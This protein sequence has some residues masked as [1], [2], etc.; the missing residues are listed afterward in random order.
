[1]KRYL[2][3]IA[4]TLLHYMSF[5][6]CT[7]LAN[8]G[9]DYPT[10]ESMEGLSGGTGWQS[11]WSVQNGSTTIPG[12]SATASSLTYSDLQVAGNAASG[13]DVFLTAGRRLNTADNGPFSD[14]VAQWSDGLGTSTGD[15]LWMSFLLSKDAANGQSVVVSLH[16]DNTA[17]CSNCASQEIAVGYFGSNSDSGGQRYWT[18]MLNDTYH[19][20]TSTVAVG[21]STLFVLRVIFVQGST[22][23]DLYIN[24]ATIGNNGIPSPDVSQAT[25][26]NNVIRSVATY[27]GSS[28]G[29]GT[30]DELRLATSYPCVVPDANVAVNLPPTASISM[31]PSSGTSPLAVT[32]S[33]SGSVDPEGQPLTYLWDFGDGSPTSSQMNP[34]VHLYDDLGELEVSLTVTDDVGQQHTIYETL[35]LLDGSGSYPCQTTVTCL[36]MASCAGGGGRVQVNAG[37]NVVTLTNS[38]SQVMTPVS[39]TL[40]DN[41]AADV[42][43]LTVAGA[44]T[45]CTDSMQ[46]VIRIDSA[47]C[48]G[49]EPDLCAMDIGTN[50]TGLADWSVERPFRNL[51][52]NVRPSVVTFSDACGCWDAGVLDEML[53]DTAGYLTFLP[54][55]TSVGAT[56]VRYV[57]SSDGGNLRPDSTYVLLY[58]GAGVIDIFGVSGVSSI[59]NRLEF[60]AGSGNVVINVNASTS[61]NHLRNF[62]LLTLADEFADLD[63][64][65]F[66]QSFVEKISPFG[67]LRFM[68][69]GQTNN[70]PLVSWSERSS[71]SFFTYAT[72]QGV[73]YEMMIRLANDLEKDL[74]LCVPHQ[75]DNNYISQM[76][77]LFRDGLDADRMVYIEYSNE[78]WN[79]IFDQAHFNSDNKPSNLS[80]GR[81]M[82][83]KAKNVFDIWHSVFAGEE[84][85]VKRVLGLQGGFNSLNEEI[86]S[87][88]D[89]SDWDYGSPTHYFGLDHSGQGNPVLNASSTYQDVMLNARNSFAAFSQAVKQ[90]YRNVQVY[91]NEV[92]TYE[93]GQ[94][95]VGNVFGIPYDYQAAMWAAQNSQEMYDMY[96][97][98]HDSIR[99]WGCKL[100][101]NFNLSS[102]QESVYG[103]WGVLPDIDVQPPYAVTARK[104]QALLDNM[105]STSCSSQLS[106]LGEQDH[107]W[108]NPCNWDASRVPTATDDV[109]VP[110]NTPYDPQVDIDAHANSVLLQLGAMLTILTGWD[111]Q[112]E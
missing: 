98:V 90:D 70:S 101:A 92:I 72:D 23:V 104:Y 80:Y 57:L 55:T 83:M 32:L 2:L 89:P 42:Y 111:L 39:G 59:P 11:P 107:H 13:G 81:A 85:R 46:L 1:M 30:F 10:G 102:K 65:P 106:W 73:P 94:H 29:N 36:Q 87:Q 48:L 33:G 75:A 60:V 18:L 58:D 100:A 53:I 63:S 5:A 67:S 21:Q 16:D 77:T 66:Y 31:T 12:Y 37:G 93:G 45:V 52:K 50:L 64:Q 25:G 22:E 84:C 91:G 17:W 7:Y 96:D 108:S 56:K 15:T 82:A 68:D 8:D 43:T 44:T 109:I 14:Y 19:L 35:T 74:W 34:P 27:L 26:V 54:Q 86:L 71:A 99:L 28:S 20:S 6:Q 69:W 95:F 47:T 51:M 24:P 40:F 38:A 9:F 41:L 78:V 103:S 76:A 97:A 4:V 49:W 3:F 110:P 88:L 112:V 61:G 105:P 79:W 62:R